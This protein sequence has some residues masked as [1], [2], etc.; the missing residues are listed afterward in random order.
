MVVLARKELRWLWSGSVK[1]RSIAVAKGEEVGIIRVLAGEE[2]LRDRNP[3]AVPG[4]LTS[5]SGNSC[6]H[7]WVGDC[8]KQLS[9]TSE[10]V[11]SF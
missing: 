7:L 5:R 4:C 6:G 10:L 11:N 1:R 2:T 3:A 9:D 8:D